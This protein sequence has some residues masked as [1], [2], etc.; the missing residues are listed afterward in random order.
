MEV[1]DDGHAKAAFLETFDDVRHGGGR[2]LVVHRDAH[3]FRAG[4]GEGRDLLDG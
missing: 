1:A 2:A 3:N 4:K